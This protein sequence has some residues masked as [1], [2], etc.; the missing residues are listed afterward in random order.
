MNPTTKAKIGIATFIGRPSGADSTTHD[1]PALRLMR[2]LE[3]RKHTEIAWYACSFFRL[4]ASGSTSSPV[5]SNSTLA[6][7]RIALS[8]NALMRA[9]AFR[10]RISAI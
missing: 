5:D 6:S 8:S 1:T 10:S 4:D 7:S 2:H 3:I 9:L